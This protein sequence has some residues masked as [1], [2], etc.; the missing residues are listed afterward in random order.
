MCNKRYNNEHENRNRIRCI[1]PNVKE[2]NKRNNL[3]YNPVIKLWKDE[4]IMSVNHD[5]HREI[6]GNIDIR[7]LNY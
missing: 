2:K 4:K 6:R 1:K 7:Y 5:I 3:P